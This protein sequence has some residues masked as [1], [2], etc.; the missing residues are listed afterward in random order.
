ML[1][2]DS[3]SQRYDERLILQNFTFRFLPGRIYG[4]IGPNGA[5]K[6]TLLRL[7]SAM[8]KPSSGRVL[9]YGEPLER[10]VPEISCVWQRPYLFQGTVIDNIGYGLR[11]RR[12]RRK[13]E[14]ERIEQLLDVFKLQDLRSQWAP[15]LSGGETARVAIARAIA[16]RP[17]I[18][19]LDEPTANLDPGNTRL[20]EEVLFRVHKEEGITVILVTHDMFQAKRLADT[21]LYLSGGRLIEY[22]RSKTIFHSP[23]S[24]ETLRFIRGEL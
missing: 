8:E 16:A 18:L 12:W 13:A 23:L 17:K 9:L 10:P 20:V 2:A 6:S 22:G 3:L 1:T 5:G 24:G 11:I 15:K 21:T 4:I 7:L 14:K 19:I